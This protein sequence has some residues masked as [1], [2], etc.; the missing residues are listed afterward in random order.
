VSTAYAYTH[1]LGELIEAYKP[2]QTNMFTSE[3]ELK[4]RTQ[5]A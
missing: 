1:S 5:L 2:N 3:Q 4:V